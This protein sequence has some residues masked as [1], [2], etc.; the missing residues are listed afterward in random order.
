[1]R[2]AAAMIRDAGGRRRRHIAASVLRDLATT[3]ALDVLAA[4]GVDGLKDWLIAGTRLLESPTMTEPTAGQLALLIVVDRAVRGR[5][6]R[7]RSRRH[8]GEDARD[9]RLRVAAKACSYVGVRRRAR[10]ARV[11]LDRPAAAGCR[12]TTTSTRSSGS[13]CCW[14]CSCCTCSGTRPLGGLDW[15][16]M[17]IVILLLVLRGRLRA[18]QAARVRRPQRVVV[19]R[20]ASPPTA[21]RVAFA[22]AGAVGRDVPD[23]QPPPA[24][25]DAPARGRTSAASSGSST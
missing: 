10:R 3:E 21:G 5:A 13:A 19:G 8:L 2:A 11:A 18:D 7:C 14:R 15:F 4:G 1:M 12:S 6:R 25:Q 22:V 9:E 16:V 20:T 17:P 23:R 24:R